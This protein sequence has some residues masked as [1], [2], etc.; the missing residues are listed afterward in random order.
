MVWFGEKANLYYVDTGGFIA[1]IKTDDIYN[2]VVEYVETIF[3]TSY[4][5]LD[6]LLAKGKKKKVVG[7]MKD[8]LG[9]KIMTKFVGLI[10]KAYIYLIDDGSEDKKAKGFKEYVIKK[11]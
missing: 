11:I 2:N 4:Y 7:L 1:Y 3:D 8:E 6:I 9:E 5:E 10:A